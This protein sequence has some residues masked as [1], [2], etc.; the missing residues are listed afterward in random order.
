MKEFLL[1]AVLVVAFLGITIG[2]GYVIG[3]DFYP[4]DSRVVASPENRASGAAKEIHRP[5]ACPW[6]MVGVEGKNIV[7]FCAEQ[8]D[9]A[10]SSQE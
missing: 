7:L 4:P 1:S 3:H 6:I 5:A 2:T 8:M 10:S 9:T